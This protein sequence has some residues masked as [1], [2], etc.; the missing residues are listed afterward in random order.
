MDS[1]RGQQK[2]GPRPD[3]SQF[4][5]AFPPLSYAK[6]HPPPPRSKMNDF[7]HDQVFKLRLHSSTKFSLSAPPPPSPKHTHTHQGGARW[8]IGP[9]R[10][11]RTVFRLKRAVTG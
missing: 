2:L 5:G 3:G 11:N 10:D 4:P 9:G 1:F 8:R 7:C 6:S